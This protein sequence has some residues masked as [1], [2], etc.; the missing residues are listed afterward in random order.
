MSMPE[1]A[2]LGAMY[3][4]VMD[5]WIGAGDASK[6]TADEQDFIAVATLL[7]ENANGSLSQY[8][9]NTYGDFA[10]R[11]LRALERI[12]CVDAKECLNNAV[13]ILAC[14][15]IENQARRSERLESLS[16][17]DAERLFQLSE[18]LEAEEPTVWESLERHARQWT[19]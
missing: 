9:E 1:D 2:A 8:F 19:L 14:E 12:G 15:N 11:A 17:A 4:R 6:L 10:P 13:T 16:D 5:R 7:N 18:R 3:Q